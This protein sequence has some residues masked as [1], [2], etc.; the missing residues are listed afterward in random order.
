MEINENHKLTKAEGHYAC[1]PIITQRDKL[2]EALEEIVGDY[3]LPENYAV[4]IY[5]SK[6]IM[7]K[8]RAAIEAAKGEL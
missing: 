8:A 3:D 6:E 5:L 1:Q 4:K 7:E 2:L